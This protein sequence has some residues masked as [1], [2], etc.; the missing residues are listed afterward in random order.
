MALLLS[1]AL[2]AVEPFLA[3][4]FSVSSTNC[5]RARGSGK[6]TAGRADGDLGVE[7]VFA[8]WGASISNS[9]S[10]RQRGESRGLPH[11]EGGAERALYVCVCCRA[12]SVKKTTRVVYSPVPDGCDKARLAGDEGRRRRGKVAASGDMESH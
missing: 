3:C 1:M 9:K 6:R 12:T 7:D 8:A 5:R 10:M 11:G 2:G 4:P